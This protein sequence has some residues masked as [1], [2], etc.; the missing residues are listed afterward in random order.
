MTFVSCAL[1]LQ[2]SAREPAI[3]P[4]MEL[5]TA[6]F[7]PVGPDLAKGVRFEIKNKPIATNQST[8]ANVLIVL[9]LGLPLGIWLFMSGQTASQIFEEPENVIH[10][11]KRRMEQP[12]LNQESQNS[13]GDDDQ[14]P[15]AS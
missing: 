9:F 4:G 8:A 1:L 3:E 11:H 14:W 7:N 2:L 13:N 5:N 15:K 6:Q 12:S 10:F